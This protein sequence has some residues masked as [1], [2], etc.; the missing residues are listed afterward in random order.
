MTTKRQRDGAR[1]AG[2]EGRITGHSG[3]VGLAVELTRRGGPLQAA[4]GY[5]TTRRPPG[6]QAARRLPKRTR[7]QAGDSGRGSVAVS[8][9]L[10]PARVT[11]DQPT[12]SLRSASVRSVSLRLAWLRSAPLRSATDRLALPR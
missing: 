6:S 4:S 9:P 11:V 3:R 10:T 5:R 1:G 2:I 8:Q 7:Q 12:T